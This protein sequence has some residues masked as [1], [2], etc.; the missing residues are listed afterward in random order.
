MKVDNEADN[1]PDY[2]V[3]R[4]SSG[5]APRIQIP[6]LSPDFVRKMYQSLNKTQASIF[7]AVQDWCFKRVWSHSP[8]PFFY[9]VSGGAGCGK[10]HVIKCIHEEA[11]KIQRQLPRFRDQGDMSQPA[12]LLTAFTGTAAFN[13]SGKTLHSLLKLPKS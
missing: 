4:E 7:Y 3:Q 11:T 8:E 2:Q 1:V 10:S 9:F 5:A 12:V 6:K 13:I